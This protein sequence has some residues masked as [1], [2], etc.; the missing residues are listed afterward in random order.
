MRRQRPA[1]P[2]S[3]NDDDPADLGL[4]GA[5]PRA[6]LKRS[7]GLW[8]L[9]AYGVGSIVG[10]GIYALIGE[11]AGASGYLAPLA[12][13]AAAVTAAFSGLA[14]AEMAS[15][16]PR[17][18]GEA[19][20]VEMGFGDE[21]LAAATGWMVAASAVITT[22]ALVVAFGGYMGAFWGGPALVSM[23]LVTLVATAVTAR[24]IDLSVGV[25]AAITLIEVGA[26]C[27]LVVF[28]AGAFWPPS[29]LARYAAPPADMSFVFAIANGATLAFFAFIGFEDI[30]NVAEEAKDARRAIPAAIVVSIVITTLLYVAVA[31]VALD[32]LPPA[33][34][35]ASPRPMSAILEARFGMGGGA[36]GLVA[37]IALTNGMIV[38]LVLGSRVIYGLGRMG[39]GPAR[40]AEV[41]PRTR[42]PLKATLLVG[43]LV[44]VLA[45]FL[46]LGAL[47]KLAS[48]A[49]LLVFAMVNAALIRVKRRARAEGAPA[50]AFQV[51]VW[52]VWAGLATSLGLIAFEAA[53]Q[54]A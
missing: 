33:E 39:L 21:R 54:F 11:L 9:I 53:R 52:V 36:V 7:I 38:E 6:T 23:V 34:L 16:A 43:A 45:L 2:V 40:L 24:G 37:L 27:L 32:T 12:F 29:D 3:L 50:P 8:G 35:A 5:A 46:P 22:A 28:G 42:T 49:T 48:I 31:V 25:V 4:A 15:R 17:A 47:A 14:F 51:P 18:A 30:V 19:V 41:D 13:L 26:L 1:A 44:L 10:A 20:Y